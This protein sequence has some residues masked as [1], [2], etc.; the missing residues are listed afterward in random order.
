M[1]TKLKST[2]FLAICC[3][4]LVGIITLLTVLK[5]QD[6]RAEAQSIKNLKLLSSG[7]WDYLDRYKYLPQAPNTRVPP[8]ELIG[9]GDVMGPSL[10]KLSWRVALLPFIGEERLYRDFHHDEPWDSPHNEQLLSRMPEV[11]LD[12]R[13]QSVSDRSKGLTH[14]QVFTGQWTAMGGIYPLPQGFLDGHRNF[15]LFI[16][17]EAT[18]PVP[19]TKPEDLPYLADQPLP[20][21]GDL[22]RGNFLTLCDDW[23]A[24]MVPANA[25]EKVLRGCILLIPYQDKGRDPFPWKS[26]PW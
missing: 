24:R 25:D 12:P 9:N 17:V 23:H 16:I 15:D 6:Y 13:M 22:G 2:W 8:P 20:P 7:M 18:E 10:S 14:W 1:K 19:W 11:Y 3:I 4:G 21:L 26:V 5:Y